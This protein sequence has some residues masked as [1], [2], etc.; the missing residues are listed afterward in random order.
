MYQNM[1]KTY[2]I[3][4]PCQLDDLSD[5]VREMR[6]KLMSLGQAIFEDEGSNMSLRETTNQSTT[7]GKESVSLKYYY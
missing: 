3:L 5:W 1:E 2:R 6:I 7:T 4:Q